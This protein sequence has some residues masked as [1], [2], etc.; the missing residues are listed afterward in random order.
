MDFVADTTFYS[1][2]LND[3]EEPQFLIRYLDSFKHHIGPKVKKEISSSENYHLIQ[4]HRNLNCFP[5]LRIADI[6]TI[7]NPLFSNQEKHKGE[8]EAIA[9]AYVAFCLNQDLIIVIDEK[10]ARNVLVNNISCLKPF[11][12][13]TVG[14]IER[15]VGQ[16]KLL[17]SREAISLLEKIKKSKFRV[18]NHIVN[19]ALTRLKGI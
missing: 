7:I 1:C 12:R 18:S 8:Q 6:S 17:N 10:N 5:D 4:N 13:G 3:I 9:I 15:S 19:D 2:F 16:Y 11:L 14:L